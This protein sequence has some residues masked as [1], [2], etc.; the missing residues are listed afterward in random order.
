MHSNKELTVADTTTTPNRLPWNRRPDCQATA[1]G[2]MTASVITEFT[3]HSPALDV[4]DH[5]VAVTAAAAFAANVSW[6]L[7]RNLWQ[8]FGFD[9]L[10]VRMPGR[11]SDPDPIDE[12]V[13]GT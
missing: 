12:A 3:M 4:L 1:G 8:H 11:T 13:N 2:M 10:V 9:F 7:F 5:R 6:R